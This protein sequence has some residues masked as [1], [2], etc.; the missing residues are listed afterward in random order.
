MHICTSRFEAL[1][2]TTIRIKPIAIHF[3]NINKFNNLTLILFFPAYFAILTGIFLYIDNFPSYRKEIGYQQ[4][5]LCQL[6]FETYCICVVSNKKNIRSSQKC[7]DYLIFLNEV[8][9]LYNKLNF[10][11]LFEPA[12]RKYQTFITFTEKISK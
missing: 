10:L 1:V 4:Q 3:T 12:H 8:N 6:Y 11:K 2:K 7:P 5:F 9:V